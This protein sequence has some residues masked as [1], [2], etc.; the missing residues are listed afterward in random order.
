MTNITL[1]MANEVHEGRG[2]EGG[3]LCDF[4]HI[5]EEIWMSEPKGIA[6][7]HIMRNFDWKKKP[8]HLYP[9]GVGSKGGCK[10]TEECETN[11]PGLFAAGA[12]GYGTGLRTTLVF[13]VRA[14]RSAAEYAMNRSLIE[15]DPIQVKEK[16]DYLD[17]FLSRLESTDG[18]PRAIREAIQKL[19]MDHFFVLKTEDGLKEGLNK[20]RDL[21]KIA[22]KK[23]YATDPRELR[24][25][26]EADF[27][28]DCQEMHA[29][30]ALF[31]TE[32]RGVHNRLDY[33]Y[34]DND[35]WIKD[36]RIKK[37][38]GEMKLYTVPI[39][40]GPLKIPRGRFPIK[41]MKQ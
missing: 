1:A 20:L 40:R 11:I 17:R 27:M 12:V 34:T 22:Y 5:P 16:Q 41:G 25:A 32:T 10:V 19:S 21:Q 14:G 6:G 18:N 28:F 39:R 4:T 38:N 33:P 9:G 26:C 35:L 2:D 23:L 30:A 8:I 13:G 15:P 29:K 24:L 36:I 37:E 31:R 3:V 7:L